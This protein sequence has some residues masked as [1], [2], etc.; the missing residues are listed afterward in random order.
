MKKLIALILIVLFIPMF[1]ANADISSLDNYNIGTLKNHVKFVPTVIDK[2]NSTFTFHIF[3]DNSMKDI[4]MLYVSLFNCNGGLV[5]YK[6][7]YA[8]K[9]GS[10]NFEDTY[11]AGKSTILKS[12]IFNNNP[13]YIPTQCIWES[14]RMQVT[15][16]QVGM[17]NSTVISRA[18]S[19]KYITNVIDVPV[20]GQ[21]FSGSLALGVPDWKNP[22]AQPTPTP[23]PTQ[24]NWIET[25]IQDINKIT[26]GWNKATEA[27]IANQKAE[28]S[29]LILKQQAEKLKRDL[30]NGTACKKLGST[31]LAGGQ[32]F[33]CKKIGTKL[34]WR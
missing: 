3:I 24:P 21:P 11:G 14:Y 26:E 20:N 31:K 13:S 33:I 2:N 8:D 17:D 30:V 34:V 23:T 4:N 22:Y 19:G 29:A 7:V 27:L 28:A 10:D 15:I 1:P 16:W 32:K 9:Y 25:H 12:F 18:T 5:G 6:R